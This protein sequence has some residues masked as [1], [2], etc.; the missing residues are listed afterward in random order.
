MKQ[1]VLDPHFTDQKL[2]VV[3]EENVDRVPVLI[4]ELFYSVLFDRLDELVHKL[5]GTQVHHFFFRKLRTDFVSDGLKQ[6]GFAQPN[7]SEDE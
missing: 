1:F 3:D 2:Y 7:V 5:L 6:M 4:P